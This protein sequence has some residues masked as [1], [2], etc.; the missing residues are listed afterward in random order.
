MKPQI[1]G[2][3][4]I[5]ESNARSISAMLRQ[6]ADNIEAEEGDEEISPTVAMVAVQIAENGQVQIYGWGDTDDLR[7][8]GLLERGKHQLLA[9][10][11]EQTS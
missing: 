11:E 2:V 10:V 3:H 5:Y 6:A 9:T 8:L 1:A 7:A 4:T